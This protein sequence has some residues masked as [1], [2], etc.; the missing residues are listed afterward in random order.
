MVIYTKLKAIRTKRELTQEQLSEKSG[1][2]LR[3][4][5]ALE[6][7]SR[8][9]NK[10]TLEN[11]YKLAAALNCAVWY[12]LDLD[13]VIMSDGRTATEWEKERQDKKA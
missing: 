4:I 5:Q 2:S 1:V 12:F 6:C 13:R 8:D 10:M 7:R 11:A 9:S 3:T